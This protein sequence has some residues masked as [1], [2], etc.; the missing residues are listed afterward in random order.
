[1]RTRQLTEWLPLACVLLALWL[2]VATSGCV[3]KVSILTH[4]QD[5]ETRRNR[6]ALNQAIDQF[7]VK[8]LNQYRK[9]YKEAKIAGHSKEE[10]K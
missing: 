2:L 4:A 8:S 9:E 1:M 6:V 5:W 7:E 10:G 3:G